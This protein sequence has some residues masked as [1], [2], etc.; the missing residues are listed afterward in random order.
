MFLGTIS[1]LDNE[2]SFVIQL[3]RLALFFSCLNEP[4]G[5]VEIRERVAIGYWNI[6]SLLRFF[7]TSNPKAG[8]GG[9]YFLILFLCLYFAVHLV[10]R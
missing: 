6:S 9:S 10:A 5:L 3:R 8:E 4:L 1:G 2:K 7:S